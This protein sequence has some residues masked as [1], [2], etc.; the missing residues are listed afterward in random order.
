[1]AVPV[2]GLSVIIR[3]DAFVRA[4]QGGGD[5]FLA[6]VPNQTLCYDRELARVAS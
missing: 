6:A 1:M 4:F 2:E 5:A 3:R